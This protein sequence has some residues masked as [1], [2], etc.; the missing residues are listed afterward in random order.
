M[1]TAYAD[2]GK[3]AN[4]LL[5]DGFPKKENNIEAEINAKASCGSKVQVQVTRANDGSLTSVFK[6]TYPISCF[7]LNGELKV[8][9]STKPNN[10]KIDT[11]FNVASVKGL[12]L[13]LGATDS[14]FNGG[15][16]LVTGPTNSNVKVDYPLGKEPK[17]EAASVVAHGDFA[18]GA[19]VTY[20]FGNSAPSFEGKFAAHCTGNAFVVNVAKNNEP[21][22]SVGFSYFHKISDTRS[23]AAKADF[24]PRQ[25]ALENLTLVTSNKV[26][27]ET[28]VKARFDTTRGAVGFGVSSVVSKNLTLELGSDFKADLS[29]SVYNVKFIYNN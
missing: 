14:G 22:L 26:N 1:A 24:V 17:I 10:T 9:L 5:T 11:S 20:P 27:D 6:P 15:F 12:K 4:D 25:L 19:K 8:Q 29:N 28:T 3:T 13:K 2:V 18:L 7:G 16:D 23:L 21:N